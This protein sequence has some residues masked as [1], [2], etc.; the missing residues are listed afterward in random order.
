MVET[1]AQ[2]EKHIKRTREDLGANLDTLETKIK[3]VTDWREYF[4]SSPMT[5]V[6]A[7]FAA[8]MVLAMTT[9]KGR[10]RGGRSMADMG[11]PR[12][13][14]GPHTREFVATFDNVTGALIG[15]ASTKMT[16]LVATALPGFRDEFDRRQGSR[17]AIPERTRSQ[18]PLAHNSGGVPG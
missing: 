14:M 15:M 3:S 18:G 12:R 7:A 17:V 5:I 2:I 16:D 8:G 10:A 11:S 6:G 13:A 1:T 9:G 4:Q